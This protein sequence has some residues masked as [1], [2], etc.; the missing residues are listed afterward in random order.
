MITSEGQ[1]RIVVTG[2]GIVGP[3][4]CGVEE[5]WQR[6]LA[7]RSGIRHLPGD[8][9]EGTGVAVGGQVPSLEED[10]VAGYDP[11]RVISAKD[12]KK[13][14]RFIEFALVAADEALEQA[15]WQPIEATDQERTATI[16]SSGVGG[17]GAIAEAVRITDSRGPRRLSPFR[18]SR[19]PRNR[20]CCR[21]AGHRRCGQANP[22]R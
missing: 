13:M 5:V 19:R 11:E 10:A 21:G 3:L 9:T 16:I 6:L 22:K 15:G 8:I 17:F 12:R 14:D 2:V 7:G 18:A 20:L 1:K 4:G